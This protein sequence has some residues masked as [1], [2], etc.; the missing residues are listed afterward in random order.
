MTNG[1]DEGLK[2]AVGAW[3]IRHDCTAA[4]YANQGAFAEELGFHSYWL[5]ENHFGDHTTLPAPLMTLTAVASRTKRIGLGTG[6]YLLPIRHPLQA[7]EEVAVLDCLS[8][9]R[10]ILGVGRG[11]Q[12]VMFRAFEVPVKEKR[13]RFEESLGIM[14]RAWGGEALEVEAAKSGGGNDTVTLSPLPIQRPHPPIWVAAFGPKALAQAGRLGLPY[15]ASPVETM[16]VLQANLSLYR[17][18]LIESNQ[19]EHSVFPVMRT[20]FISDNPSRVREVKAALTESARALA[21]TATGA[22]RRAGESPV[23]DWALVGEP[24]EIAEK[25]AEYHQVLGVSHLIAT[26]TR[27]KDV[28]TP[29]MERSLEHLA[30]VAQSL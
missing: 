5:P 26:R 9:G 16:S 17:A 19:T 21:K 3:V 23:E 8:A 4:D 2:I 1:G 18:A 22:M 6:S 12:G 13:S 28:R 24:S 20:T 15:I 14:R 10:V 27:L 30:A 25:V 29:E 7:A 11:Y